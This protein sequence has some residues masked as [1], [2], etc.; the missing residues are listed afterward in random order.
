MG[1]SRD[2]SALADPTRCL[3]A[4][5]SEPNATVLFTA[6]CHLACL[7][8]PLSLNS[9]ERHLLQS[10]PSSA[11]EST[12][13]DSEQWQDA[14]DSA[15]VDASEQRYAMS[16][17]T[18]LISSGLPWLHPPSASDGSP[19]EVLTSE[20]LL[21]LAGRVLGGH[22]ALEEAGAIMRD[23]TFPLAQPIFQLP[24]SGSSLGQVS[25][26]MRD[27]SLPPSETKPR[28]G[29][30]DGVVGGQETAKN[31]AAA[32]GV[33]TWAA[34]VILG[35][36]FIQ[37]PDLFHADFASLASAGDDARGRRGRKR[38]RIHELGA[39]TGLL[40]MAAAKGL[41]N[42]HQDAHLI[43]SDFHDQVLDNL[44]FNLQQNFASPSAAQCAPT[45]EVAATTKEGARVSM[46]VEKVD[47]QHLHTLRTAG[48]GGKRNAADKSHLL[49][50]AD[51]VYDPDHAVWLYSSI[52]EMLLL[53][54]EEDDDGGG[55][56]G[57]GDVDGEV[58]LMSGWKVGK[59]RAHILNAIRKDGKFEGLDESV[60]RA[61][62]PPLAVSERLVQ[63]P[64]EA[65]TATTRT[66]QLRI[67]K[68]T[69]L[70]KVQ[71]L[72]RKDERG[73][74]WFEIGWAQRV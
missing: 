57:D 12:W 13:K 56:D 55:G 20:A 15:R 35:D 51:V 3:P 65:E 7:Y 46:Q 40:G 22:A 34:A 4:L 11:S 6:L 9:A 70:E 47:W 32:V 19:T 8:S 28:N 38:M 2:L 62:G 33:Q 14:L 48:Q 54:H 58:A 72:G 59:A 25:I 37:R 53:P 60:Q 63:A 30:D 17:L 31:A 23:F 26:Q 66:W 74:L 5:R 21:D 64:T 27:E 49:L 69:R 39:G 45:S 1:A 42:R 67:L 73:Y 52:Q 68:L 24:P 36:L 18:R 10:L 43:L 41:I 44:R 71:R 50:L 16:W 61:F 29:D